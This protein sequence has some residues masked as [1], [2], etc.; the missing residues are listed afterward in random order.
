MSET[1][2]FKMF[3]DVGFARQDEREVVATR[4]KSAQRLMDGYGQ[5]TPG[6][7]KVI[8]PGNGTTNNY[9]VCVIISNID[10]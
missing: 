9:F 7:R 2:G 3:E 8:E 4:L 1:D 6:C 10:L 5:Q